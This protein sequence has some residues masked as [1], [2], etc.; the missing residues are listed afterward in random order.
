MVVFYTGMVLTCLNLV[1]WVPNPQQEAAPPNVFSEWRALQHTRALADDIGERQVSQPGVE[2]G[3]QYLLQQVEQ[4]IYMPST[5][6]DLTIEFERQ[7]VSGA[8][9]FQFIGCNITNAY[10]NLTNVVVR[11]TPRKPQTRHAFLVNAHFD[12]TIGT[13]GASDCASCVAVGLEAL[14]V[15]VSDPTMQLLAPVVFLFNGGEETLMQAAHGFMSTPYAADVGAFLNLE[16]TGPYGLPIMFQHTGAWAASVYAK[17]AKYPRGTALSQDFFESGIIPADTDYKMF[18][19]KHQGRLPG[20][21]VAFVLGG[22]AYHTSQDITARIRPGTLQE[23]GE[24]TLS[25]IQGFTDELAR[26]SNGSSLESKEEAAYYFDV[27]WAMVCYPRSMG[28]IL[29]NS[30]LLMVLMFPGHVQMLAKGEGP[31]V[32]YGAIA[33][34]AWNYLHAAFLTVALPALLG[35][36]RSLLLGNPLVFFSNHWLGWLMYVPM[37]LL[38]SMIPFACTSSSEL[39]SS[40][41]GSTVVWGILGYHATKHQ[42]GFAVYPFLWIAHVGAAMLWTHKRSEFSKTFTLAVCSCVATLVG[43]TSAFTF[44]EHVMDKITLAGS[45]P[46]LLGCVVSDGVAGAIVGAGVLLAVGTLGPAIAVSLKPIAKPVMQA[47]VVIAVATAVLGSVLIRPYSVE[48]PK[49]VFCQHLHVVDQNSSAVSSYWVAATTDFNPVQ[50]LLSAEYQAQAMPLDKKMT[51]YLYPLSSM[52]QGVLMPAPPPDPD[53]IDRLPE[54]TLQSRAAGTGGAARLHFHLDVV[55]PCWGK[56]NITGPPLRAWS[57]TDQVSQVALGSAH[58]GGE[59]GQ[60]EGAGDGNEARG[61]SNEVM[62]IV[63][64]A[65]NGGAETWDFWLDV[66]LGQQQQATLRIELTATYLQ[67]AKHVREFGTQLPPWASVT[68][69]TVYHSDWDFAVSQAAADSTDT[70]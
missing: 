49:R 25:L 22:S 64:F 50:P 30:P 67:E 19:S 51:R 11:V 55:K 54:L 20:I 6:E 39:T 57:F 65:G 62:H 33:F 69:V 10:K 23:L 43:V 36:G 2:S 1:L 58:G 41:L 70:A 46:G 13:A 31:T 7:Q 56:V 45:H 9:N 26:R 34:G 53:V 28:F 38:G 21:D 24:T 15:L 63:R 40:V 29:H 8:V 32:S 35:M 5:R 60:L 52:L 61:D 16:S 12:S 47:L 37:A 59:A 66:D 42:L 18:S 3:A 14:R 17:S 48:H 44:G 27:S 4:L 68:G